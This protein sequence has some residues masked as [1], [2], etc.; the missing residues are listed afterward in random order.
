MVVC[1]KSFDAKGLVRTLVRTVGIN[2][3]RTVGLILVRTT[4]HTIPCAHPCAHHCA[5]LVRT[6]ARR[7]GSAYNRL[8]TY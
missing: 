8:R 6:I 7:G 3:V 4:V 5:N 1:K 2:L